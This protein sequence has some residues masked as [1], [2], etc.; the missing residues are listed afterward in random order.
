MRWYPGA[1]HC[2]DRARSQRG[3][4]NGQPGAPDRIVLAPRVRSPSL[5]FGSIRL[6][7]PRGRQPLGR[8]LFC[9]FADDT[10]IL[11][12]RTFSFSLSRMT[13][14]LMAVVGNRPAWLRCS[15]RCQDGH[16]RSKWCDSGAWGESPLSRPRATTPEQAFLS[17][18]RCQA[19]LKQDSLADGPLRS[20]PVSI[21]F[22]KCLPS[23][24]CILVTGKRQFCY[25]LQP[26]DIAKKCRQSPNR[27]ACVTCRR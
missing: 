16:P 17:S 19:S 1:D 11:R 10:G 12:P 22:S 9:L 5:R 14:G 4:R 18:V 27:H 8:L 15:P 23:S 2:R 20:W 24:G 25:A 6:D 26:N 13:H 3:T 7:T 21:P